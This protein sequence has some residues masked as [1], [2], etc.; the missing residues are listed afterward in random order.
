MVYCWNC[1]NQ[2][3]EKENYCNSCGGQK[4]PLI[5]QMNLIGHYKLPKEL[6]I[7]LYNFYFTDKR[8]IANYLDYITFVIP[9]TGGLA[10]LQLP[11][12]MKNIKISERIKNKQMELESTPFNPN[13]YLD[14]NENNFTINYSN[15]REVLIHPAGFR[16][17]LNNR[18]ML[19]ENDPIFAFYNYEDRDHHISLLIRLFTNKIK[20]IKG[21]LLK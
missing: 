2:I 5:A 15:I 14:M 11:S 8:L 10:I 12:A 13:N 1:G 18:N 9:S 6:K 16:L 21:A 19:I 3:E 7:K 4:E 17:I 20:F